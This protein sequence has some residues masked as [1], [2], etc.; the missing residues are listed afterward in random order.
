MVQD[1]LVECS[2]LI[3]VMRDANLSDGQLHDAEYWDW[4]VNELCLRFRGA[5]R[6]PEL[7]DGFYEDPD[8]R[9]LVTDR[10]RKFTVAV[11]E[12]TVNDL[13]SLLSAACLVFQQ[14]C[15]YLSVAGRVEF[16]KAPDH[17]QEQQLSGP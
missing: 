11:S 2:F 13:R 12:L 14:K 8:T 15:I 10:S 1:P 9:Q 17:G 16:V 4:L 7:Y 3:P 5:T 6:S